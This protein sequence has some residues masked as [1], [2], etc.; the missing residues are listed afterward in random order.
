[1]LK[2]EK[3]TFVHLAKDYGKL[4]EYLIELK[5]YFLIGKFI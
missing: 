1:M 2:T 3:L 4:N 5:Q